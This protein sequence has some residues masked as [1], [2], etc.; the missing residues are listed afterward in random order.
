[1]IELVE[2]SKSFWT[3]RGPHVVFDRVS[4]VLPRHRNT[5]ILGLNGSGKSTLLKLIAGEI[6]PSGGQIIRRARISWPM[7]FGGGFHFSLT[8]REN[9][10]FVARIYNA[11]ID[12]V[13]KF[14]EDFSELGK[15]MDQRL[16]DYSSGM[17]AKLAFGL[18]MAIDFDCYLIDE[19]TAVGDYTFRKKCEDIFR[20][21]RAKSDLIVVSH[22]PVTI[23]RLCDRVVVIQDKKLW[24]YENVNEGIKF[25][26][27]GHKDTKVRPPHEG[28][29]Q[30]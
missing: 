6:L 30:A 10:R 22:N 3:P 15:H 21:R 11:D 7:G 8:G 29:Q 24:N 18:S 23:R 9:L 27:Q 26:E 4:A 17:R 5:G 25:Y 28:S 1:M 14:V 13:T 19:I 16:R 20:E 12:R 2:L